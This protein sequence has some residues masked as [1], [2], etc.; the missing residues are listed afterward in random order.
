MT[1][2]NRFKFYCKQDKPKIIY[3]AKLSQTKE[4]YEVSWISDGKEKNH[5]YSIDRVNYLV[6]YDIW[7]II[8]EKNTKQEVSEENNLE[9]KY[10]IPDSWKT[11]IGKHVKITYSPIRTS[12]Y[13]DYKFN[14]R[15]FPLRKTF[16][17]IEFI[18]ANTIYLKNDNGCLE[19]I[20]FAHIVQMIEE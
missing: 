14:K 7:I 16:G 13:A 20:E 15:N 9:N 11:S 5:V 1:L 12:D 4:E 18:N 17:K 19:V 3:F 2:K 10:N 6:N 8:S